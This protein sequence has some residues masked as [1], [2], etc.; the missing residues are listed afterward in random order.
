M[1][2]ELNIAGRLPIDSIVEG[3]RF[4]VDYGSAEFAELKESI[5][6]FGLIQPIVVNQ[7]RELVA[8]GRRFRACQELGFTEIDV[9][10]NERANSE[11]ILRMMELEENLKRKAMDWKEKCTSIANVHKLHAREAALSK[12]AENWTQKHTGELL[13]ISAGN[14][15]YAL[16]YA[17]LLKDPN[18]P[19]QKAGSLVEAIQMHTEA[20]ADKARARLTAMT[21]GDMPTGRL[22]I[23]IP[24]DYKLDNIVG[25][26]MMGGEQLPNKANTETE[27]CVACDGTGKNTAG[28]LCPICKGTGAGQLAAGVTKI[29]LSQ[30]LL[31]GDSLLHMREMDAESIDHIVT[32]IPYGI[33]MNNLQQE[34]TGMDVS[35]TA[36]EHDVEENIN[37]MKDMLPLMYR[38]L[39]ANAY[40]VMWIDLEHWQ[41]LKDLGEETG[42]KVQRWPLHWVKTH[43]CL[44][45]A[46]QVNFTKAVEHAIIFR[47]GKARLMETRGQNY[48]MG[49]NDKNRDHPFAKPIE[50]WQWIIRAVSD[51]HQLVYDPFAGSGSS[52]Q[53]M[54]RCGR[55]PLASEINANHFNQMVLT[56][57]NLYEELLAPRKVVFQ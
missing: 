1:T 53:A 5:K 35:R 40:C 39:K 10:L 21:M 28:H 36:A 25:E 9:V 11:I 55:R 42:F 31:C 57:R 48:W 15:S 56:V 44:N 49:S 3:E 18:H 12:E 41:L 51:E 33:D 7:R 20:L 37:M 54:I 52:L 32:D 13:G 8:G 14:V 24:D 27:A 6:E 16:Q 29:P 22:K 2:T 38:V 45:Q 4:R 50:L 26:A 30:M 23:E 46:A 19:I 47:K 17:A 43:T 34:N